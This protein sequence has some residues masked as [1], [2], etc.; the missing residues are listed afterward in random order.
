MDMKDILEHNDGF[1]AKE[2][3]GVNNNIVVD[4]VADKIA[5]SKVAGYIK[6][7]VSNAAKA[8]EKKYNYL[9][10]SEE[11]RAKIDAEKKKKE[12]EEKAKKE[13]E[14]KE[15]EEA[16]KQEKKRLKELK[17]SYILH[18]ACILCNKAYRESYLVVPKSHGEYIHGM[19]QLNVGDSL[20]LINVR[21]FG[22][23][24]SPMNPAVQAAAK[25][26]IKEVE[27]EEGDSFSEKIMSIFTTK[28]DESDELATGK[29]S[30]IQQCVGPC[31]PII[32]TNWI[33]GKKDVLVDGKPALLGRCK[34]KCLYGG[35]ITIYTSGQ[36]E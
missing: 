33:D 27:E 21:S 13:K 29:D 24:N 9:T 23:C 18:T 3:T 32:A 2:L 5:N 28:S 19:P 22:I 6:E 7:D 36:R 25:K 34:L 31:T 1:I 11:E 16:E 26:I 10:A 12:E 15:A 8:I 35:E 4:F 14:K 17:K 20:P 30:L